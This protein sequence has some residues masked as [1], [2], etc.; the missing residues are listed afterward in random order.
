MA[1]E[2]PLLGIDRRGKI[3][4]PQEELPPSQLDL[5]PQRSSMEL[6][7]LFIYS[8]LGKRCRRVGSHGVLVRALLP[9]REVKVRRGCYNR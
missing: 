3:P 6:A 8:K 5:Q 9:L 7:F 4:T 2:C 1:G